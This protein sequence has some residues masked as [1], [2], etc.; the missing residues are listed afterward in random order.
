MLKTILFSLLFAA[1]IAIAAD[2][3]ED[4][5]VND[6]DS[7]GQLAY[8]TTYLRHHPVMF[9]DGVKRIMT[10]NEFVIRFKAYMEKSKIDE[11]ETNR[12]LTDML[13]IWDNEASDDP[14]DLYIENKAKCEK[15]GRQ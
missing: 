14:V 9:E 3:N 13:E 2:K 8:S 5:Y 7:Y 6:C 1:S 15:S 10:R 11:K 4:F 12:L